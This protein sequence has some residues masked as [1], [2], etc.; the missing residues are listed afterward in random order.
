MTSAE[1]AALLTAIADG[2]DTGLTG[3]LNERLDT[4]AGRL[5]NDEIN[6]GQFETLFLGQLAA[7]Y[8]RQVAGARKNL[9]AADAQLVGRLV[10][11]QRPFVRG[12]A[13][14]INNGTGTMPIAQRVQMYADSIHTARQAV[15]VA[16]LTATARVSWRLQD[17][18]SNCEPCQ[19]AADGGPYTVGSLPGLPGVICDG[20]PRCRCEL[21]PLQ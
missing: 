11:R 16:G 21:V 17:D 12:L 4:L 8:L 15:V 19:Q 2:R 14:D 9:T 20:G 3:P 13:A 10:E 1:L 5:A 6:Q 7:A 18:E